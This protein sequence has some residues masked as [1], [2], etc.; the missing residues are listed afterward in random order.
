MN[1]PTKK[2]MKWFVSRLIKIRTNTTLTPDHVQD[3]EFKYQDVIDTQLFN[4]AEKSD[5]QDKII[6]MLSRIKLD[7][8]FLD[9]FNHFNG[10]RLSWAR[11]RNGNIKIIG[12]QTELLQ[13]YLVKYKLHVKLS[14]KEVLDH[15]NEGDILEPKW[16][17][18]TLVKD[19]GKG[20]LQ[21]SRQD[22][23]ILLGKTN[24]RPFRL[25][26]TLFDPKPGTFKTIDGVFEAIRIPRDD[27]DPVLQDQ[28]TRSDRQRHKIELAMKE[29]QKIDGLTGRVSLA[30][31]HNKDHVALKLV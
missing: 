4:I 21:D 15:Y 14:L 7:G 16:K 3:V 25:V 1:L 23:R 19:A 29:L 6:S 5:A 2:E 17:N 12:Y 24:T 18:L 11:L 13:A 8:I 9:G 22:I 27:R 20:Y 31:A 26:A 28:I 10:D 30:Y